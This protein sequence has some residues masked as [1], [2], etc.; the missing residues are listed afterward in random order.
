MIIPSDGA[1]RNKPHAAGQR[2]RRRPQRPLRAK[3]KA[4]LLRYMAVILLLV[5]RCS[6]ADLPRSAGP[7]R[8]RQSTLRAEREPVTSAPVQRRRQRG[9]ASG[10]RTARLQEELDQRRKKQLAERAGKGRR[11]DQAA[12]SRPRKPEQES[13]GSAAHEA[14]QRPTAPSSDRTRRRPMRRCSTAQALRRPAKGTSPSRSAMQHRWN[15]MK[16]Y[17]SARRRWPSIDALARRVTGGREKL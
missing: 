2:A 17:L 15:G 16:E 7:H 4:A 11:A 13:A 5:S 6:G 3:R 9:A 10:R 1:K 8:G 14:R 12:G